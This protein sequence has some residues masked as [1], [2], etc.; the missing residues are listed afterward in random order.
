VAFLDALEGLAVG[1][2]SQPLYARGGWWL[3]LVRGRVETPLAQ[4]QD[5]LA[6]DLLARGPEDDEVELV[7]QRV[8]SGVRIEILPGLEQ[9]ARDS[10]L[11]GALVPA[12]SI[13][14]ES[15]SRATYARWLVHRQGEALAQ[16][17]A[18]EWLVRRKAA[19]AGISVSEDEVQQRA[20]EFVR[21]IIDTDYGQ[22]RERW[23]EAIGKDGRTEQDFLK[24]IAWR[25]RTNLLVEKLILRERKPSESDLRARYVAG[26]GSEG[27]RREVSLIAIS[28]RPEDVDRQ[29]G[30]EEHQRLAA[31]A[32][33]RARVKAQDLVR[34]AR[35]GED[36][37]ALA[38]QESDDMS[39]RA[40]GGRIEGRWRSD[41]LSPSFDPIVRALGVG[42]LSDP[43]PWGPTWY[44]FRLDAV[45]AV[46]FD[47][48]R[49]ELERE[50]LA[51][52]PSL[53]QVLSYRNALAKQS[54]IELLPGFAR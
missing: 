38:R 41:L 7:R 17:F 48:V 42:A 29:V 45:R 2:L 20:L 34:R 10:E 54:R 23:L 31:Q 30:A 40:R 5:G 21:S 16:H 49:G 11:D 24:D 19:A 33:E 39:T 51:E 26:Y 43:A 32:L 35:G 37:A 28:S 36:F 6:A 1:E 27:V 44:V 4:V 46:S 15:V 3:V 22:D 52:R 12:L 53:I 25:L 13:D 18:E 8:A 14:G 9:P 50:L 47:E